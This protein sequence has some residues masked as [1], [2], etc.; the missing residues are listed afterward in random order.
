MMK[1]FV[2]ELL[3]VHEKGDFCHKKYSFVGMDTQEE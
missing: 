1:L 2:V 3:L